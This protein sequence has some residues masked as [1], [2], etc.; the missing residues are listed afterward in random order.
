MATR[1]QRK[2]CAAVALSTSSSSL[3]E[4]ETECHSE[5]EKGFSALR[6]RFFLMSC[7]FFFSVL[8]HYKEKVKRQKEGLSLKAAR[9]TKSKKPAADEADLDDQVM[10]CGLL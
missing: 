8:K 7:F 3:S 1:S 10:V 9:K 5:R 6:L 2:R 4:E